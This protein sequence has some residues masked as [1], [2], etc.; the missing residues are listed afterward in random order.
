MSDKKPDGWNSR[1]GPYPDRMEMDLE[2]ELYTGLMV[3]AIRASL[4]AFG[5]QMTL[6]RLAPPFR[7]MGKS[8]LHFLKD[9]YPLE[10]NVISLAFANR[11]ARLG[12][13]CRMGYAF[14]TPRGSYVDVFDCPYRDTLPEICSL[15]CYHVGNGTVEEFD[16]DQEAVVLR[17][18][19]DGQ[20]HC[21]VMAIGKGVV[22][23]DPTDIGEP[24]ACVYL[25][26]VSTEVRT[27]WIGAT[28]GNAWIHITNSMVEILGSELALEILGKNM[29]CFG[30]SMGFRLRNRLD[31]E[32]KDALSINHLMEEL[33]QAGH[34]QG[35]V[36]QL[37]ED[38]V[39]KEIT[40]CPFSGSLK[41]IG[42]QFEYFSN[43]V[44]EIINPDFEITHP[45]AMCRG[46][47]KCVRVI[48]RKASVKGERAPVESDRMD[49]ETRRNIML[50]K[51]RLAKGE[52]SLEDYDKIAK[53]LK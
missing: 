37:T 39:V 19:K 3:S 12:I 38:R 24:L 5:S 35:K 21:R 16:V 34:Q 46:D 41:E 29:R 27:F 36:I 14:L 17:L 8:V 11:H 32:G 4:D 7:L 48:A 30:N 53:V 23:K 9:Y 25:N 47:P 44:C 15:M 26:E 2:L 28:N 51:S 52:I 40:S 18:E 49:D 42:I 1:V 10:K 33:N 22:I 13:G 31:E 50:L 20:R 43:G 45:Q 6:K